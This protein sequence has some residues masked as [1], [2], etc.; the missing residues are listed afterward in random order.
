MDKMQS[1]QQALENSVGK[2]PIVTKPEESASK[3][4]KKEKKPEKEK[5]TEIAEKPK[6]KKSTK[7]KDT[8]PA[9]KKLVNPHL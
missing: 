4:I 7:T 9:E 6:K 5:N 8:S 1:L 2:A 3:L